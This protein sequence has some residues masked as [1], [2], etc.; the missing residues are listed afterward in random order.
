MKSKLKTQA[1]APIDG[2]SS[3]ILS[4]WG[5]LVAFS[6]I[7]CCWY[8]L[9]SFLRVLRTTVLIP[10]I[11]PLLEHACF[12]QYHVYALVGS[13]FILNPEHQGLDHR[14]HY[15]KDIMTPWWHWNKKM[16]EI[17]EPM[18]L[19]LDALFCNGGHIGVEHVVLVPVRSLVLAKTGRTAPP[20]TELILGTSGPVHP[21]LWCRLAGFL[22]LGW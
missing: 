15:S 4:P 17:K 18:A 1:L 14:N 19:Y 16:W 22:N 5:S 21:W 8:F 6:P 20:G 13:S 3:Q 11:A 2:A 9:V 10:W 7:F 12:L